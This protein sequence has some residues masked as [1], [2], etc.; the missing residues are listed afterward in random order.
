MHIYTAKPLGAAQP[1]PEF[2]SRGL[3]LAKCTATQAGF[4]AFPDHPQVA[5][6][7]YTAMLPAFLKAAATKTIIQTN[8][9][10]YLFTLPST[11]LLQLENPPLVVEFIMA[12]QDEGDVEQWAKGYDAKSFA[13]KDKKKATYTVMNPSS[14][15]LRRAV[16]LGGIENT[17]P[18]LGATNLVGE[19][20]YI[21]AVKI[22]TAFLLTHNYPAFSHDT[23]VEEVSMTNL[24]SFTTL[25]RGAGSLEKQWAKAA[26][27]EEEEDGTVEMEEEESAVEE[28]RLMFGSLDS[29]SEAYDNI[30]RAAPPADY[31]EFL[32]FTPTSLPATDGLIFPYFGGLLEPDF[33]FVPSIMARYFLQCFGDDKESI[34]SN[35]RAF[36]LAHGSWATTEAGMILQHIFIGVSLA[37]EAQAVMR[38]VFHA[39]RYNGFALCGGRFSV[40]AHNRS[41]RPLPEK[42]F[43]ID[44]VSMTLHDVALEKVMTLLRTLKLDPSQKK[45]QK[46]TKP[47]EIASAR[48]LYQQVHKRSLT[49]EDR[50]TISKLAG[51]LAFPQTYWRIT[52]DTVKVALDLFASDTP[53]PHDSPMYLGGGM[54][55]EESVEIQILAAF[56]PDAPSFMV[57][58]G[59]KFP[60]PEAVNTSEDFASQLVPGK[61]IRNLEE[62]NVAR[63]SIRIAFADWCR[64]RREKAIYQVSR[65]SGGFKTVKFVNKERDDVWSCIVQSF[66]SLE[67]L[68]DLESEP[69]PEDKGVAAPK[70]VRTDVCVDDFA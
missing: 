44:A 61:K 25:K 59:R 66:G 52:A 24:R 29:T 23:A 35:H 16:N 69:V 64:M 45:V 4:I 50:A 28:D 7:A 27:L 63:K 3:T 15:C 56:G 5:Y 22:L 30:P 37:V 41:Y 70:A 68:E 67:G 57:D 62:I 36:K 43:H 21:Q 49:S 34:L 20:A 53:P 54:L 60:I 12:D 18:P 11:Q 6:K 55:G 33:A 10:G 38:P 9:V 51:D 65:R 42:D 17:R 19:K 31:P 40:S 58:G 32:F 1:K 39:N 13:T 14:A 46:K 2:S 47:E 8:Q 48:D 26:R